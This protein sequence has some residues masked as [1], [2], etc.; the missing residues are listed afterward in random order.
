MTTKTEDGKSRDE[1]QRSRRNEWNIELT[2]DVDLECLTL[3]YSY[4]TAPVRRHHS[5]STSAHRTSLMSRSE[6]SAL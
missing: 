2:T 1:W 4:A 3:M 5:D 6:L